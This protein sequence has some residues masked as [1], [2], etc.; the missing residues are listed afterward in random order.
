MQLFFLAVGRIQFIVLNQAAG[1]SKFDRGPDLARG[2]DLG[3]A[4]SKVFYN[5]LA[6]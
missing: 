6:E 1:R 3:H 4:L 5:L 2:P